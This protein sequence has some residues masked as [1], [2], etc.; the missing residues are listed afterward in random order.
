MRKYLLKKTDEEIIESIKKS[1]SKSEAMINLGYNP[2]ER[3]RIKQFAEEYNISI[4]HFSR[5]NQRTYTLNEDYFKDLNNQNVIYWLGFIMAD[6]N[7]RE[8]KH[9]H[10]LK[11]H[12]AIKDELHL[13]QL[14]N[15]LNYNGSLKY[16]KEH[17]MASKGCFYKAQPSVTLSVSS[18][19]LIQDLINL[20]CLPNKTQVGTFISP[21][22]PKENL[23]HFIRGYF[24]GDCSI[25]IDK[26]KRKGA[27][28]KPQLG[29]FILGHPNLL[30]SIRNIICDELNVSIPKISQRIGVSCIKW[31]GNIQCK[32]IFDWLYIDANRY[33][34]RKKTKYDNFVK[35]FLI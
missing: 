4:D 32:K 29:L 34:E 6:G 35:E 10:C 3:L 20:Q 13:I 8:H 14:K 1:H 22:I 31:S 12:L 11:V 2:S 33:L 23:R 7:I 9:E 26:Q 19:T 5:I 21:L 18:K 24:D 27:K 30:N 17:I 16:H 15:D 25:V 28:Y